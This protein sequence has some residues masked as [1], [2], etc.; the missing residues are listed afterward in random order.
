MF[1]PPT[2]QRIKPATA[3]KQDEKRDWIKHT[4]VICTENMQDYLR[5]TSL[6][7]LKYIGNENSTLFERYFNATKK[8][9]VNVKNWIF[10][11]IFRVFFSVSFI[12]VFLLSMYYI[13]NVYNKWS[14]SGSFFM[15]VL[16]DFY[17]FICMPK[18]GNSCDCHYG[19]WYVYIIIQL[20]IHSW[21]NLL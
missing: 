2:V 12:M 1:K 5:N 4:K 6:H 18:V 8:C 21:T 17:F 20:L 16:Y 10:F 7:G 14:V 3:K 15:N 13:S 11:G 9:D 19:F